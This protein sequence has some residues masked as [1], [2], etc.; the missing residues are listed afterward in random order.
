MKAAIGAYD[1]ISLLSVDVLKLICVLPLLVVTREYL[2]GILMRNKQTK[3]IG[4]GK[5]ISLST[6][7]VT[8]L[9]CSFINF[10]NPAIMGAIGMISAEASEFIYL[11]I[12]NLRQSRGGQLS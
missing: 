11:V 3:A 12:S 1:Q 7:T 8:M 5:I 4:R 6:L 10:T 9:I 2:W